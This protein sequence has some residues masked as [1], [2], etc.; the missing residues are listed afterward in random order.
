MLVGDVKAGAA[1]DPRHLVLLEQK[2]DP[3]GEFP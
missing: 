1:L 2:F 3:A